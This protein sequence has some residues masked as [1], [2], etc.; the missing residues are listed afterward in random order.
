M[1]L[2]RTLLALPVAFFLVT[3]SIGLAQGCPGCEGNSDDDN[4]SSPGC[5]AIGI[6][7]LVTPGT[8]LYSVSP[9]GGPIE[10]TMATKCLATITRAWN[11]VTPNTGM[12]FCIEQGGTNRCRQPQPSSGSGTG[13]NTGS[14]LMSCGDGY[15]WSI[16]IQ[17]PSGSSLSATA[18]GECTP[19]GL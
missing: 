5:G 17:C 16:T 15:D 7:V 3:S 10:C 2:T 9:E 12:G 6:S 4:D 1:A 11:N 13:S 8:C 14:W 18:S 19:C